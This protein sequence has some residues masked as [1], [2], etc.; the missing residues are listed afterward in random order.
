MGIVRVAGRDGLLGGEVTLLVL[1]NG[2]QGGKRIVLFCRARI[3]NFIEELC[4]GAIWL[5]GVI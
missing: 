5:P 2:H 3:L 1:G 4:K